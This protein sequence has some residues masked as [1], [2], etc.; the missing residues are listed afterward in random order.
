[1]RVIEVF[2]D[3]SCPFTHA[4]LRTVVRA[5]HRAGRDDV[6]LRVRA[7]PLELVNGTPMSPLRAAEH[8]DTLRRQAV[9]DLF[10]HFEV[11]RF[12]S[13]SLPALALAAAA[14]RRGDARGE[15]VSLA[16][17]EALFEEGRD[18]SRA[19]VL[20]DIARLH[21]VGEPGPADDEAVRADWREGTGRGVRGSPH[22]FCGDLDSFC[23]SLDISRDDAGHLQVHLDTD[24]L[25]TLS[26]RLP[27]GVIRSAGGAGPTGRTGRRG[28]PPPRRAGSCPRPP[29]W[30]AR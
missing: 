4:G 20:A 3:V 18:I 8:V 21:D 27:G 30:S 12:P 6:A 15:A 26:V 10:T 2:A 11:D 9:P 19:D 22:F 16:L 14:Y 24:A 1:M 28:R 23:P 5:R 17:R 7:W 13:T 29:R 25:R